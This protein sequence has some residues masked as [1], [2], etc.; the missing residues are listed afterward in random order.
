MVVS[1]RRTT[2][3]AVARDFEVQSSDM[4]PVSELLEAQ[5]RRF[6]KE[7]AQRGRNP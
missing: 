2:D 1:E 5:G 6:R 3:P 7:P 4:A